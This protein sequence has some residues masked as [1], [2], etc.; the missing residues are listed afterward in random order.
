[1]TEAYR[2]RVER[3]AAMS[4][5]PEVYR[6]ALELRDA[7]VAFEDIAARLEIDASAIAALIAIGDEKLARLLVQETCES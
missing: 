4:A 7:G 3:D 2:P 1:M 6:T 5:L